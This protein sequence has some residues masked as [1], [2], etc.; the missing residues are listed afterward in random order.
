MIGERA[1]DTAKI[2][3][4]G[5]IG[6]AVLAE[7][8]DALRGGTA[9]HR[10]VERQGFCAA[11]VQ[12]LIVERLPV[13]RRRNL[14]VSSNRQDRA[15]SRTIASPPLQLAAPI[16]L[17]VVANTDLPSPETPPCAQMPPPLALVC[18]TA[19]TPGVVVV[20]STTVPL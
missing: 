16:V 13:R 14:S 1:A 4:V 6:V 18:Q 2:A 5:Q 12:I 3:A 15:C 9:G 19:A 10:D 7:G 11:E 17:P 8:N 20:T